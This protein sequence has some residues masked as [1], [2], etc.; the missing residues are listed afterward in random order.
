MFFFVKF[1]ISTAGGL[2]PVYKKPV[3]HVLRQTAYLPNQSLF[4]SAVYLGRKLTFTPIFFVVPVDHTKYALLCFES[5]EAI[6]VFWSF[7]SP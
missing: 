6:P 7:C 1:V 3:K 5:R 2:F 4:V